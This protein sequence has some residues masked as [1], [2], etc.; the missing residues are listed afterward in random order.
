MPK[1]SL[2]LIEIMKAQGQVPRISI[3]GI[4]PECDQEIMNSFIDQAAQSGVN[5]V[6]ITVIGANDAK[7]AGIVLNK[8]SNINILGFVK[9]G[10]A[11]VSAF[12]NKT[13]DL[14]SQINTLSLR[15]L[16]A[17]SID[18]VMEQMTSGAMPN[19]T[20]IRLSDLEIVS[21]QK[22]ISAVPSHV[23]LKLCDMENEN[24]FDDAKLRAIVDALWAVFPRR[25]KVASRVISAAWLKKFDEIYDF[26]LAS[27][28]PFQSE[29]VDMDI[30][31]PENPLPALPTADDLQLLADSQAHDLSLLTGMSELPEY[32]EEEQ[33]IQCLDWTLPDTLSRLDAGES[34]LSILQSQSADLDM[35]DDFSLEAS[36]VLAVNSADMSAAASSSS[37]PINS[38]QAILSGIDELQQELDGMAARMSPMVTPPLQQAG[39][40]GDEVEALK[41]K[42]DVIVAKQAA[43]KQKINVT[44]A[45]VAKP[46]AKEEDLLE[47]EFNQVVAQHVNIEEEYQASL[48]RVVAAAN[49]G[50]MEAER[51]RSSLW[52]KTSDQPATAA[53]TSENKQGKR[54]QM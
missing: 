16:S 9:T 21:I 46:A 20:L 35:Q 10:A 14:Q 15:A 25:I 5:S 24:T 53:S 54:K 30:D 44:G 49:Y 50:L 19:L 47:Q 51:H 52:A 4:A 31:D 41:N 48:R 17:D 7:Q 38:T 18:V 8:N 2:Q 32:T 40:I 26:T 33:A 12:L 29:D 27:P 6:S 45:S 37:Q 42:V 11:S 34:A 28:V 23:T 13:P 39:S 1:I 22:I 3:S 36:D 43:K